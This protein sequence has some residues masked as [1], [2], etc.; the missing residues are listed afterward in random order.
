MIETQF[1]EWAKDELMPSI[2]ELNE[3]EHYGVKGMKWG[4]RR[5]PEQLGHTLAARK[6][7]IAKLL[8]DA[9]KKSKKKSERKKKERAKAKEKK[10]EKKE[11][12]KTESTDELR[13]KLLKSTDPKYIYKHRALLTTKELQDRLTRIDTEQKVQKLTVDD[14]AKKAMKKGEDTLK[15]I[16][17]MAES[18]GKVAEAYDKVA[19][20][21]AK[22]EKRAADADKKREE[23]ARA[24]AKEESDKKKEKMDR[25]MERIW[26]EY[27]S[28]ANRPSGSDLPQGKRKKK[29]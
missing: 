1:Q 8:G 24:R 4:V 9:R 2:D 23:A 22:A 14:K 29:K 16:A 13:E 26:M 17:A 21:M 12:K 28:K 6:R 19:N 11:E 10:T 20:S 18:I 3:L 27:Y 15:S 25:D 5:T 7:K